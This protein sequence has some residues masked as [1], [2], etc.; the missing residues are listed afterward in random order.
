MNCKPVF[1]DIDPETLCIS[2]EEIRKKITKKTSAILATHVYGFP[3]NVEEI[4]SIA[5][6][7][8]LKVI[9]DAAH[10]F[11]VKYEGNSILNE[12]DISTISFHA[13]KLFHTAEGGALITNNDEIAHKISYMRNFGHKGQENF[14]GLGINGKNSELHAA[15]GLCILPK[16]KNLIPARKKQTELYDTLLLEESNKIKIPARN[17]KIEYNFSYYPVIFES[18]RVLLEVRKILNNNNIFPRRYFYP[19]LTCLSYANS[20]NLPMSSNIS[21]R[22]LCLPLFFGLEA[23]DIK[24]IVKLIKSKVQ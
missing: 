12:G 7:H 24:K 13:T 23:K 10:C 3:C 18:E 1:A 5:G 19:S 9:Y 6:Q 17:V 22:V 4:K 21:K 11:G 2:P 16:M 8:S 15:M 20:S 14:W